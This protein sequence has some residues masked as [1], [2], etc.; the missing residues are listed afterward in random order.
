MICGTRLSRHRDQADGR[1]VDN[2]P[3]PA[4]LC[5]C[6][7]A[8][9]LVFTE[10]RRRL[11]FATARRAPLLAVIRELTAEHRDRDRLAAADCGKSVVII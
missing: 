2:T 4:G 10:A 11:V 6:A 7:A 8:R 3:E 9:R 5:R 1:P